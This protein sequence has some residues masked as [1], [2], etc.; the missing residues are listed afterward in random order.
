[1]GKEKSPIKFRRARGIVWVCDLVKSSNSLNDNESV[2]DIE[3]FI[4]RLYFVSKLIVETYGGIFLKWT[5]D[6]FLAFFE[7]ELDRHKEATA[8]K[9]FDAAWHLT[10]MSNVT[11]L[12]LKPKR[13]FKIRHGITYEKDALLMKIQNGSLDIIGRAVVL[14]FRLSGIQADFPSIVTV[15][16]LVASQSNEFIKWRPTAD[17]KLKFFKGESFGVNTVLISKKLGQKSNKKISRVIADSEKAISFVESTEPLPNR[18]LVRFVEKMSSGPGWC[19]SIIKEEAD[20]IKNDLL[21]NL[22][23]TVGFL[24]K[25]KEV[26]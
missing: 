15:N 24:K 1:M 21:A 14:A 26:N 17:E 10:F 2:D 7:L 3:K 20:F 13:K 25:N 5:G 8:L 9:V 4:P 19:K 12:G 18:D 6:G 11:Q 16:E 23:S 22:K